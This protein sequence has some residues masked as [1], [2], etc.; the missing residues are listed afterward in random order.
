MQL[1][2]KSIVKKCVIKH[3]FDYD[4]EFRYDFEVLVSKNDLEEQFYKSVEFSALEL[5]YELYNKIREQS[6]VADNQ[7]STVLLEEFSLTCNKEDFLNQLIEKYPE[8]DKFIRLRA[9]YF[10]NYLYE[11][12]DN[13][14]VWHVSKKFTHVSNIEFFEGDPHNRGKCVTRIEID[15]YSYFYKPHSSNLELKFYDMMS[16]FLPFE[17]FVILSTENF[18]IHKEIS[19]VTPKEEELKEYFYNIGLMSAVFYFFNSTDM[20]YENLIINKSLPY[21]FDLE[22]LV[23]LKKPTFD[24][25]L[26]QFQNFINRSIFESNIFPMPM[27][28]NNIDISAL[29]GVQWQ[30]DTSVSYSLDFEDDGTDLVTLSRTLIELESGNNR[31][32]I[33]NK[34]VESLE[35]L[36]SIIQG[37][38]YFANL[39]LDNKEKF[40][41]EIC[42]I[43][44]EN[45]IRQIIRPTNVYAKFVSTSLNPYYLTGEQKR[46]KIFAILE[47][48]I[49]NNRNKLL[50]YEKNNLYN[51]DIPIFY[52]KPNSMDLYDSNYEVIEQ[53]FY[54]QNCL[55]VI[56]SKIDLFTINELSK[57]IKLISDSLYIVYKNKYGSMPGNSI[58][59]FKSDE[60]RYE[61]ANYYNLFTYEND[62]VL[63]FNV[64]GQNSKL[65]LWVNDLTLYDSG[66]ILLLNAM[67]ETLGITENFFES[68]VTTSLL[69]KT[70]LDVGIS[71]F[72]GLGSQFYMTY[73]LYKNSQNKS[74]V[75]RYVSSLNI[76]LEKIEE[77]NLEDERNFDYFTGISGLLVVLTNVYCDYILSNDFND[78][79]NKIYSLV[80][81]IQDIILDKLEIIKKSY[82]AGFAHGLSGIYYSLGRS[83]LCNNNFRLHAAI[84]DLISLEDSYYSS[85]VNNYFDPRDNTSD[86]YFLCY[87]IVGIMLSRVDLGKLGI[88]DEEVYKDKLDIFL[89]QL[90]IDDISLDMS[91]SLCHGVGSILELLLSIEKK[92]N[93]SRSIFENLINK[94]TGQM[95][96]NQINGYGDEFILDTFMN[97]YMGKNY[98]LHRCKFIEFPSIVL[99]KF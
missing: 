88:I 70:N 83:L 84:R 91:Y 71:A 66:G 45:M 14:A 6:V 3:F 7:S 32:L 28:S 54:E 78:F 97:G 4:F 77:Y 74:I 24:S 25:N 48:G 62:I 67:R 2:F 63:K 46:K 42:Q 76:I 59:E 75:R 86:K 30:E 20:H 29:T 16:K 1:N 23:S 22:T 39:V 60:L 11:V 33:G 81:R 57:Q 13:L 61:L 98:I 5:F 38:T 26:D 34:L 99:L 31:I 73:F 27:I 17:N 64:V 58:G 87:G 96:K 37:F 95:L 82:K 36:E 18:S 89:K 47:E 55:D 15:G 10:V 50:E 19:L 9:E 43:L 65:A 72:S 51:G 49:F 53:N 56:I 94:L 35:Y 69:L 21:F 8:F 40:K 90:A 85:A 52:V 93:V 80:L 44:N 79:S 68:Y 41:K 12:L 92:D